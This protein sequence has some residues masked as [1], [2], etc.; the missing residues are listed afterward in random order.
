MIFYSK[1]T[2]P[3][4]KKTER[5][6]IEKLSG[7]SRQIIVNEKQGAQSSFLHENILHS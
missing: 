2:M 3:I 5:L 7:R 4:I 6:P 1:A